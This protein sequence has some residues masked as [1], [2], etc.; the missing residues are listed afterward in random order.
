MT[1]NTDSVVVSS[2]AALEVVN[3]IQLRVFR[4]ER[5]VRQAT[6]SIQAFESDA[7]SGVLRL[8]P[9]PASAW[10]LAKTLSNRHSPVL[11]T[12]SLDI[13]QVA[14]A[15]SLRAGSFLTFDRNQA[16]LAR[17]EGFTTPIND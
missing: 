10:D 14:I 16:A 6:Q 13:L 15:I 12:R 1:Q 2:L 11:G 8:Q 3:A 7:A 9:V 17:A 5:T 4:R